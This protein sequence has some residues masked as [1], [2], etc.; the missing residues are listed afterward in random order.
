MQFPM[1]LKDND[2]KA[3]ERGRESMAEYILSIGTGPGVPELM[4]HFFKCL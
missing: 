3:A 2:K 1:Q 4:G